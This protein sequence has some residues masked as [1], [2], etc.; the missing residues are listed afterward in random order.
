MISWIPPWFSLLRIHDLCTESVFVTFPHLRC[1]FQVQTTIPKLKEISSTPLFCLLLVLGTSIVESREVR[2]MG[3]RQSSLGMHWLI[4]SSRIAPCFGIS[5][6]M[7]NL[8]AALGLLNSHGEFLFI[9]TGIEISP[10]WWLYLL[11]CGQTSLQPHFSL[12]INVYLGLLLALPSSPPHFW[13]D[14]GS[15]FRAGPVPFCHQPVAQWMTNAA[16]PGSCFSCCSGPKTT[17]KFG[18]S[19]ISASKFPLLNPQGMAMSSRA[20]ADTGPC[21]TRASPQAPIS[22]WDSEFRIRVSQWC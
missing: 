11:R 9:Q 3:I 20:P 14:L 19:I 6:F 8:P 13:L 16:G 21:T 17:S 1:L 18:Q 12:C 15:G 2:G 5:S 7:R 4:G 22:C 10:P